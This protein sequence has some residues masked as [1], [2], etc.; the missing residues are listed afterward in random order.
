MSCAAML[1]RVM[2]CYVISYDIRFSEVDFSTHRTK[3]IK[4]SPQVLGMFCMVLCCVVW[5]CV[6]WY[7]MMCVVCWSFVTWHDMTWHDMIWYDMTW[8]AIMIAHILR[9]NHAQSILWW[10][11]IINNISYAR[12]DSYSEVTEMSCDMCVTGCCCLITCSMLFSCVTYFSSTV[13]VL[14][15]FHPMVSA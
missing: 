5:C 14:I 2:S 7:V 8:Y 13:V 10:A 11:S 12:P 4:Y 1:C 15:V 3:Y 9:R 6:A